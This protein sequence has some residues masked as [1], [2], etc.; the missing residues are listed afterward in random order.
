[1]NFV[2]QQNSDLCTSNW[3]DLTNNTPTLNLT[4]LQNQVALPL[5]AGN[6]FYRLKTP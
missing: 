4:N 1:M 6:A 3:T 2:L 5:P